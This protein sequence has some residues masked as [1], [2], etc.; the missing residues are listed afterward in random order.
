VLAAA[1]TVASLF[2]G[3][4]CPMPRIPMP[5]VEPRVVTGPPELVSGLYLQGGPLPPIGCH[6]EPHGPLA[7]TL[8]VY[9][10]KTGRRVAH[11]TLRHA[12]QLFTIALHPGSYRVSAV[13]SGGLRTRPQTVTIPSHRT[14]RQDVFLDVP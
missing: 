13:D 9:D 10:A 11:E 6:P 12:G 2:A 8:T 1:L 14:V 3:P 4:S 5:A 7:G